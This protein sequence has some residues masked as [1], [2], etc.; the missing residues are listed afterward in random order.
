MHNPYTAGTTGF[1]SIRNHFSN[2]NHINNHF[3]SFFI[4]KDLQIYV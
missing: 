3:K 1:Q 4:E 2:C